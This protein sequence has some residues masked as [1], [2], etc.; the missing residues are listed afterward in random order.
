MLADLAE[1]LSVP[2]HTLASV[3]KCAFFDRCRGRFNEAVER[4]E[5]A[6]A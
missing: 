5:P 4:E 1:R 6:G 3:L 2:Q